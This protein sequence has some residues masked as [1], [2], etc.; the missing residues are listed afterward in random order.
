MIGSR[1]MDKLESNRAAAYSKESF[2]E[3]FDLIS[4]TYA[5]IAEL[6]GEEVT[7]DIVY[8]TDGTRSNPAKLTKMLAV[9]RKFSKQK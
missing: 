1:N 8:N 9:G 7:P 6:N 5:R 4:R 2:L 3:Y